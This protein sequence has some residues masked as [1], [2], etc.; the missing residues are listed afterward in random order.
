[1]SINLIAEGTEMIEQL[2]LLKNNQVDY[3]QGH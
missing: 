1:M 3:V 2:N